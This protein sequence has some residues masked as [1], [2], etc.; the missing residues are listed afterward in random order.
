MNEATECRDLAK[1]LT[2]VA[3]RAGAAILEFYGRPVEVNPKADDSPVTEADRRAEEI[4]VEAL[5]RHWPQTPV[6][7][8]EATA[9]GAHHESEHRRFFLVDP[10]DGTREFIKQLDDFTVNIALIEDGVP[11]FGL[12]YAPARKLLYLTLGPDHAIESTLESGTSG[13]GAEAGTEQR[14]KVRPVPEAG[15]VAVTSR[16]HLNHET[17]EFLGKLLIAGRTDAGSSLKFALVARGDADVYPRLAPT[18][19]WDTAAGHAVLA[20]AGGSVVTE[21]GDALTYGHADRGFRNPGFI[22]WGGR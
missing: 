5:A 3:S 17:E 4:I 15:L 11:R 19:E 7:A 18:M 14:L 16:S 13:S 20:A 22:A 1:L 10:L 2:P 6:I 9:A 8:E 21:N 12:V